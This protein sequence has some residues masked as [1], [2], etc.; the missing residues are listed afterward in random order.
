MPR[1]LYPLLA[2]MLFTISSHSSAQQFNSFRFISDIAPVASGA[3]TSIDLQAAN[4]D[5]SATLSF[6][7]AAGLST[8][9]DIRFSPSQTIS[10]NVT[11]F[12]PPPDF[13][14]SL[15]PSL[16]LDSVQF[17]TGALVDPNV[18]MTLF[19]GI[20]SGTFRV[21]DR[22]YSIDRL[23]GDPVVDVRNASNN[24][25]FQ[26]VKR[27][28]I[29][30]IIDEDYVFDYPQVPG[31]GHINAMESLHVMDGLVADSLGFSLNVDQVVY[32]TASELASAGAVAWLDSNAQAFGL[33]DNVAVFFFQGGSNIQA[34]STSDLVVQGEPLRYQFDSA[35]Y[36]GLLLGLPEQ[37]NTLTSTDLQTSTIAA[38][39][40]SSQREHLNDNPPP[41]SLTQVL[42]FDEPEIE[43]TPEMSIP[44]P[45]PDFILDAESEESN[46]GPGLQ[47]DEDFIVSTD[48]DQNSGGSS[49]GGVLSPEGLLILLLSF[50]AMASRVPLRGV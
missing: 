38:Q 33:E 42:N 18:R 24:S 48:S 3:V 45:I 46:S 49:G 22:V 12:L 17:F 44:I 1:F 26:S 32:R 21:A 39:W 30:A 23:G 47:S 8:V 37:E 50:F 36:L 7:D 16:N 4:D 31:L 15:E 10:P 34:F 9:Y 6:L 11:V 40:N 35:Y 19:D 43:V 29:S 5:V 13:G 20:W 14:N 25:D 28:K 2:L 41:A 27:I